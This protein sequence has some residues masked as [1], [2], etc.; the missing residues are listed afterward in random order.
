MAHGNRVQMF[1]RTRKARDGRPR[2]VLA[3]NRAKP[4]DG[5]STVAA[6]LAAYVPKSS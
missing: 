5:V 3:T 2:L 4:G 6:R 1:D